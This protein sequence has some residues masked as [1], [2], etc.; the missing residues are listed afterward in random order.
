MRKF[1]QKLIYFMETNGAISE[2]DRDVY[3]YA[4]KSAWILGI[5]IITSL[6]IGLVLR[7][8]WYCILLLLAVIP[9]RS[10]AGGY[11]A[12]NAWRCYLLSCAGLIAILLWVKAEIPFQ[13]LLTAC[14]AILSFL[15]IFR[16]APLEA[17][18][19]PLDEVEKRV[20]GKRARKIVTVETA[21]GLTCL[22]IEKK[23]ALTILSAIIWC[24][25]GYIGWFLE[26]RQSR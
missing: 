4:L 9:L 2:E 18:N 3:E 19:K 14:M 10:D 17:D 24:A 8:P 26:K 13:G 20:I 11:H 1:G 16:Y 12:P 25:I 7:A 21:V 15:L 22:L 6:I 23:A 5:N